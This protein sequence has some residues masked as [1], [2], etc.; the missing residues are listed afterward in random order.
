MDR[1]YVME[2]VRAFQVGGMSRRDFLGQATLAVGAV[3]A[4][5]LVSTAEQFARPDLPP[6]VAA[7][8]AASPTPATTIV[9]PAD[10]LQIEQAQYPDADGEPLTGYLARPTGV[11]RAPAVIVIQEW[12]GLDEHIKDVVR[13]FAQQGYVGLAPDLYHGVV[14]TEP[15]EA[16]KMVMQLDMAAAIRGFDRP[17][18]S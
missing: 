9:T 4:A 8:S 3:A 18:R 15:D 11:T 12:W 6:V 5:Q 1:I 14:T 7:A 2:L 17:S 10:G 16:R 13:R